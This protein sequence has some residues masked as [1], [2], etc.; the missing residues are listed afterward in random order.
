MV[1]DADEL[2]S[3]EDLQVALNIIQT[4]PERNYV[5]GARHFWRS[6]RWVCDDPAMPTRFIKPAVQDNSVYYLPGH[7]LHMGYAQSSSIIRYKMD[8]HGHKNEW[9]PGWYENKFLAWR[10]GDV[11]VHP[12]CENYWTPVPFADTDSTLDYLCG[13][14]PYFN[15]SIIP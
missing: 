6:L 9:R 7:F 11:D 8:I 12:T 10:P 1:V 2:W 15:L 4:R 14:H 5:I 3:P 13:D